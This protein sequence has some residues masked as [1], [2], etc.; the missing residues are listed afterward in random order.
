MSTA[1]TDAKAS[2]TV[3]HCSRHLTSGEN[4]MSGANG[5]THGPTRPIRP[6]ISRLK[7]VCSHQSRPLTHQSAIA[8]VGH[9]CS[10]HLTSG[11]GGENNV[12][13]PCDAAGHHPAAGRQRQF[14]SIHSNRCLPERR[15]STYVRAR[16]FARRC[17]G[18]QIATPFLVVLC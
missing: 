2:V 7:F 17:A 9:H 3:G 6:F 1:S 10:R 5:A 4:N 11:D 14:N 12:R 16:K 13:M 18:N 15:L 8:V